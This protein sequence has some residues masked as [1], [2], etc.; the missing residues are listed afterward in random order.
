MQFSSRIK[1]L[2]RENV[3]NMSFQINVEA[4]ILSKVIKK[5]IMTDSEKVSKHQ[6]LIVVNRFPV[7][8]FELLE[9]KSENNLL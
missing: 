9:V 6:H 8:F 4:F 2:W 5:S 3:I 1:F 7:E